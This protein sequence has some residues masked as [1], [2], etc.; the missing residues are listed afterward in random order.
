MP[1]NKREENSIIVYDKVS[2]LPKWYLIR[3][4]FEV[5]LLPIDERSDQVSE[6]ENVEVI[7]SNSETIRIKPIYNDKDKID[8][9]DQIRINFW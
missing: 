8:P 1:A 3:Y 5:E 6:L 4:A 2:K 7:E 9:E